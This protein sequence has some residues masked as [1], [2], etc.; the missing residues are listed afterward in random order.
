MPSLHRLRFHLFLVLPAVLF[1]GACA[2]PLGPGYTIE[3]QSIDLRYFAGDPPRVKV[4]A[5]YQLKNT[6]NRSLSS[7]D[8]GLPGEK[9]FVRNNLRATIDGGPVSLT[10]AADGNE[11]QASFPR[12]WAQKE[13]HEVVLEYELA[14]PSTP[15][16]GFTIAGDSL[17]LSSAG[18]YP[19]LRP[20]SG[21]FGK[22]GDRQ[23]PFDLTLRVPEGFLAHSSGRARGVRK[24]NGEL[25]YRFRIGK[26]DAD[27]FIIA[28]R[29]VEQRFQTAGATVIFWTPKRQPLEGQIA[30]TGDHFV[31]T[32]NEYEKNFGALGK[33]KEPYRVVIMMS[34]PYAQLGV[35]P[36][37][38]SPNFP[39][40]AILPM[41]LDFSDVGVNANLFLGDFA[42]AQS[43][44][45]SLAGSSPVAMFNEGLCIYA[46]RFIAHQVPGWETD[47]KG[48]MK[49]ALLLYEMQLPDKER[50]LLAMTEGKIPEEKHFAL[51]KGEMFLGALED[52][53][54][55]D[56]LRHALRHL[57]RS[58]RGSKYGYD[59]LRSALEQ[60]CHQDLGPMFREWLTETGIPVDFRQ[61]YA[62]QP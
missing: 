30:R 19:I 23:K 53:C 34:W 49:H 20:P 31:A 47:R 38:S 32:L 27:P 13:V 36:V 41:I 16:V 62:T 8:V 21:L 5:R 24:E 14:G 4:Q 29:F 35:Y 33:K 60:E 9:E 15:N 22:G 52:R 7:L 25:V 28:G 26:D 42:L 59:E 43:W 37:A 44:F 48:E 46:S 50:S 3:K 45:G 40:G 1:L 11:M 55:P 56:N 12:A 51:A 10:S 57:A 39:R 6:G 54:G 18:W 58:L 17:F 61:R 2:A